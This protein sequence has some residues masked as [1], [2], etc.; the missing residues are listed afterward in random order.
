M[1]NGSETVLKTTNKPNKPYPSSIL[2]VDTMFPFL[3]QLEATGEWMLY[4]A[5]N[6]VDPGNVIGCTQFAVKLTK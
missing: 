1:R 5:E 3:Q 6:E 4:N 2:F